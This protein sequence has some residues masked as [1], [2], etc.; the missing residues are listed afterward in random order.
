MQN[1]LAFHAERVRAITM[2]G[3]P[4]FGAPSGIYG[5]EKL[6]VRLAL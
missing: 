2:D 4:K 1:V 6:S 3:E 5:L